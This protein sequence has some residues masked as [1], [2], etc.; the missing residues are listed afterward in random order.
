MAKKKYYYVVMS[1]KGTM[2]HDRYERAVYCRDKYLGRS[3]TIIKCDTLEEA[4]ERARD[5][6]A[7]EAR[8]YGRVAPDIIEFDKIYFLDS[9]PLMA[10]KN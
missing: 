6:L 4:Q 10:A 9:L 1:V 8:F 3:P 5:W 7:M 2:I